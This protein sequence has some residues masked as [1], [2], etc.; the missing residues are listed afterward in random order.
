LDLIR[1]ELKQ[2]AVICNG[3]GKRDHEP[4]LTLLNRVPPWK[5]NK[6]G[7]EE[8]RPS[9]SGRFP[10]RRNRVGRTQSA[11]SAGNTVRRKTLLLLLPS[12][13]KSRL[14]LKGSATLSDASFSQ[15]FP[16]L[17]PLEV[18]QNGGE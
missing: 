9:K 17:Q 6:A 7:T 12:V 4:R 10:P 16:K 1:N 3:K 5:F 8:R 13:C 14:L 2:I 18:V 11:P 15:R